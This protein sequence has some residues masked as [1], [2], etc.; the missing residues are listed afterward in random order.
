[1]PFLD[2]LRGLAISLVVSYHA[3]V[4]WPEL[5]PY[6]GRFR[7]FPLFSEGWLGLPLFFILSGYLIARTLSRCRSIAEFCVRRWSRLFPAMVMCSLLLYLS[8]PLFP[9]RPA[10]TP[11][12]WSLLPGLTFIDDVW[13]SKILGRPIHALEGSFWTLYTEAKFYVSAAFLYFFFGRRAL[14][15]G[16]SA[17][18]FFAAI[19]WLLVHPLGMTSLAR[20]EKV[21]IEL[22]LLHFGWFAAGSL[23]F[24]YAHEQQKQRWLDVLAWLLCAVSGIVSSELVPKDM[25]SALLVPILFVLALRNPTAQR[26]LG[27]P[28]LHLLGLVSYP[29]FLLHENVMLALLVKL[30]PHVP[31]QWTPLLPIPIVLG[32]VLVAYPIAIYLAPPAELFLRTKLFTPRVG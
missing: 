25:L 20:F 1:M 17:A 7:S 21:V 8:A 29:L 30:G 32:L 28:I 5:V 24:F 26:V 9:E 27:H 4:R 18:F 11:D 19:I 22:S 16:L 6:H 3:Y 12:L 15:L 2:G 23:W 14:S 31:P 10:G 13:W